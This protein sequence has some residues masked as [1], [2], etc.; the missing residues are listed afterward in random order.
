MKFGLSRPKDFGS[1]HEYVMYIL[2]L[3][4]DL[5]IVKAKLPLSEDQYDFLYNDRPDPDDP[6]C[7]EFK[8]EDSCKDRDSIIV[9]N[10][11]VMIEITKK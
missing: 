2:D 11:F 6:D 3:F 5:G 8:T 9:A 4:S 7:V 10:G 1:A